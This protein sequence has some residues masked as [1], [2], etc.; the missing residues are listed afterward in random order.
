MNQMSSK[1]IHKLLLNGVVF[2]E[3]HIKKSL[4]TETKSILP[5]LCL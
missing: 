5:T 4:Q 3:F 2:T 1:I